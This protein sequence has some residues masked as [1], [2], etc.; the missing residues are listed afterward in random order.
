MAAAVGEAL[1]HTG[2]TCAR[3]AAGD[4]LGRALAHVALAPVALLVWQAAKVYTRREVHEAALL[5]GL[6]LEE[7]L[8]RALK[9]ALAHPRPPSCAALGLCA[10]HG[11]PS[12]HTSLMF[13]YLAATTAAA[14]A[15]AP[16]RRPAARALAAAEQAALAAAA[17]G[18]AASRLYLGYHSADQVAAGAAL[19]AAYGLA[20]HAALAAAAPLFARLAALPPLAA[21]GAKDTWGC[22]E[23]LAVEQAAHARAAKAKAG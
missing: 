4:G 15:A 20:L 18:V 11:M 12:S 19:G 16:R 3:Y 8:A 17:L 14:A 23:P 22:A 5:L 9:H 10:S 2:L 21:L 13:A 6:V 1:K 7:G